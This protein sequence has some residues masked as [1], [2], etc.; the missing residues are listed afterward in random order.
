[1]LEEAGWHV[2]GAVHDAAAA[3]DAF[4][5]LRPDVVLVDVG[6]P[7]RDGF[8]LTADLTAQGPAPAVVLTS[9]R[10]PTDYGDRVDRCGAR[11]FVA[12]ADLT[13]E[14]L[15]ALLSPRSPDG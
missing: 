10:E 2:V 14:S 5:R 8:A 1:M 4:R 7:G 3:V 13:A 6:L 12:K 15:E 9:A 11:G